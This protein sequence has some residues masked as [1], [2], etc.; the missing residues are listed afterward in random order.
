MPTY[1]MKNKESGEEKEMILSLSERE[2]F[3]QDNPDWEQ[4]LSTPGFVSSSVSTLRRAGSE[5]NDVLKKIK[6]NS[7]KK[8]TINT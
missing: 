8:N 4:M 3:L 6:S 5:W 2:S 1:T 7:G